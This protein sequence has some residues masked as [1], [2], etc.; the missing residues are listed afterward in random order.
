MITWAERSLTAVIAHRLKWAVAE[1]AKQR[2]YR[3][4][5]VVDVGDAKLNVFELVAR[6]LMRRIPDPFFLQIGAH[7]GVDDDPIHPLVTRYGWQ[8]LLVEPQPDVFA[9]LVRNYHGVPRL[10]FANAAIADHDG[11]ATLYAPA[12]GPTQSAGTCLVSFSE[13]VLRR[14]I[15]P[16]APIREMHVPALTMRSLLAQY[17]VARV[18][19]L[20]IDTEGY[21][22]EVLKMLDDCEIK[23]PRLIRFEYVNLTIN[24]RKLCI[25]H[26][27]ARGYE[28]LV[29]GIDIIA[30]MG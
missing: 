23:M 28:M 1:A 6:D 26:L 24:E 9:Q 11:T 12:E 27:V 8:G 22:F 2:G 10:D 25:E 20:Q 18:D 4:E 21:D 15:G 29:D 5:R 3:I 17:N 19:L 14:R 16:T 30:Y 13:A 7:D